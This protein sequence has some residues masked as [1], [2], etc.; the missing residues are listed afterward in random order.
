MEMQ[1]AKVQAACL[2]DAGGER[3]IQTGDNFWNIRGSFRIAGLLDI[4]TQA[5]LVRRASGSF[6]LLDSLVPDPQSALAISELTDGG[7]K[8]EAVLNLHPF[9]TLHVEAVHQLFPGATLFG[10]Q[11]HKDRLPDLP[12]ATETTESSALHQ[13]FVDDLVFSVPAG[14]DFISANEKVHFSSVLAFHQASGTIHVDDTFNYIPAS[15]LLRMTPLGDT[16]SLHPTLSRALLK[17]AGAAAEFSQW[18][19]GLIDCW[20]YATTLCAAHNGVCSPDV[21]GASIA[22]RMQGALDRVQNT[23][24]AHEQR[25]QEPTS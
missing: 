11:R 21:G 25:Y 18:A 9:H 24:A 7:A 6:V 17:R 13:Q 12:W 20:Q 10:T 14:V 8:I 15:G 2:A 3:L 23:L 22:E 1:P 4:G 19:E 5:S 16:V